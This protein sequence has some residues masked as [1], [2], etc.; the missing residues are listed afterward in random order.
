MPRQFND[1]VRVTTPDRGRS[2]SINPTPNP[3]PG[4]GSR[5]GV[6]VD[7]DIYLDPPDNGG[8]GGNGGNGA[9]GGQ[10]GADVQ[11]LALLRLALIAAALLE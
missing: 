5:P 10:A 7:E 1:N 4:R 6:E 8:N 11:K 9:N 3:T 2:G